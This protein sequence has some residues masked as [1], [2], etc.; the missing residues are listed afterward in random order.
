M[1]TQPDPKSVVMLVDNKRRDL[2]VA[3]LIAHQL[4]QQ[5]LRC[6]LEPLQSYRG[7]LA[8]YRPALILFNHLT[9]AHL[10]D[11]AQRLHRMGVLTAVLLNEGI[12]YDLD[13]LAF[14][15]GKHHNGAP[16][17]L[18]F[19]WNEVHKA[20]LEQC[21]FNRTQ[22][23]VVGVP[24]FD[25]YCPPWSSIFQLPPR[26]PADR[27]HV[28]FCT[29]FVFAQYMHQPRA[30]ADKLFGQW[31][32]H[33]PSYQNYWEM[34]EVNEAARRQVFAFLNELVRSGKFQ[35]TLR[36]HPREDSSGYRKWIEG[37]PAAQQAAV[38]LDPDTNITALIL[39]CDL[40]ISCETCTTALECWIARKPTIE[41]VLQK[42]PVFYH[43]DIAR[44]NA[45]CHDPTALVAL[46]EEQRVAEV[47]AARQA[48]RQ[49][50]LQKWCNSPDGTSSLKLA[51]AIAERLKKAPVPDW[52]KLT[53]T[54]HRRA[55]KLK[56]TRKIGQAYHFDPLLAVKSRLWR[57][58]FAGSRFRYSKAIKPKDVRQARAELETGLQ[59][60]GP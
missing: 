40:E 30:H 34:I 33:I 45:T 5:G 48:A 7:A 38:K 55:L 58:K 4:E 9:A 12:L 43:P 32:D 21:G 52:S 36:P 26:H 57:R 11:Y 6:H 50:H 19:C 16:I 59:R 13:V 60:R 17:D 25:F 14:N 20:A 29:N 18:F 31:K 41:L 54:D 2:M 10:V 15:A 28:L 1:Q 8:A 24:R 56:L 3:T 27:P 51:Q 22:I 37:L 46:V 23:E 47:P 44:L 49:A 35:I 42:H 39:A 53:A